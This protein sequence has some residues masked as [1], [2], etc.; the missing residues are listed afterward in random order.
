MTES[1]AVVTASESAVS[2]IEKEVSTVAK[3]NATKIKTRNLNV[4]REVL[5]SGKYGTLS[6]RLPLALPRPLAIGIGALGG[7]YLLYKLMPGP[8]SLAWERNIGADRH[9]SPLQLVTYHLAQTNLVSTVGNMFILGTI[10]RYHWLNLGPQSFMTLCAAGAA[11]GSLATGMAISKDQSYSATGANAI[12]AAFL[13]FHAFK[14]PK[15]FT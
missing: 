6:Q 14:T 1:K 3:R 8:T 11:G 4:M 7:S 10:G 12:G 2:T 13:T 15:L 9:S 5:S